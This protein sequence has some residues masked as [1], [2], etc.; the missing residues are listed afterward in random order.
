MA[1][2]LFNSGMGTVSKTVLGQRAAF[3]TFT[4]D[5]KKV[6][7][8]TAPVTGVRVMQRVD[9]SITKS[10][11]RDFLISA[12]GD[13]PVQIVISG[14]SIYAASCPD[15]GD[16][17]NAIPKFYRQNRISTDLD[18]RVQVG[19]AGLGSS[20]QAFNCAVVGLDLESNS[21]NAQSGTN[22]YTLT[23]VGVEL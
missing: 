18:K 1:I 17:S 13:Q 6:I 7:T 19:I 4:D 11:S 15:D 10:L 23:L 21:E 16:S 5:L 22:T 12:F 2:K 14:M 9:F 8:A 20:S 3:I